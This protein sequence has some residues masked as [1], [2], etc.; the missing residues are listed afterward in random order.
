MPPASEKLSRSIDVVKGSEAAAAISLGFAVFFVPL[1]YST[2][3]PYA[4]DGKWPISGACALAAGVLLLLRWAAGGRIPAAGAGVVRVAGLFIAAAAVSVAFSRYTEA[5]LR[6]T[7]WLAAHVI[8]FVAAAVVFRRREWANWFVGVVLA[9]AT[10]V[11]VYGCCQRLRIGDAGQTW[12]KGARKIEFA[13]GARVLGTIGLETALG[14]YMATCAV[15]AIGALLHFRKWWLRVLLAAAALLMI[16]CMIF[17]GTRT[18]W[19]AFAIGLIVSVAAVV[20][21]REKGLFRGVDGVVTLGVIIAGIVAAVPAGFETALGGYVA[22]CAVL[23]IGALLHLRKWWLRVLLAAA[24]LLMIACMIFSGT[25]TAWFAFAIGLIVSV[26]AVVT[27]REKGAFCRLGRLAAI[28]VFI[29]GIAAVVG[30]SFPSVGRRL[31]AVRKHLPGRVVIWRSAVGMF[32]ASPVVGTGPG[33]FTVHFAEF[34]PLDYESHQVTSVVLHAHCEYLDV[35]AETG[36]LGMVSF[37]LLIGLI[38]VGSVRALRRPGGGGRP[39]LL[40]AFAASVTMLAHAVA[41]VD[42]RYPTCWLMLWVMMG[43][44]AAR[45]QDADEGDRA[46]PPRTWPW[47][48]FVVIA[49]VAVA[50]VIWDAQVWRPYQ[51]RKHLEKADGRQKKGQWAESIE[52]AQRALELDPISVPSHCVLANSLLYAGEYDA[53]LEAFRRLQVHSPNYADIHVRIGVLNALLGRMDEARR[54]LRL[55][56]RYGVAEGALADADALSDEQL[57]RRA[58][59]FEK[60]NRP[61]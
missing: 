39:L 60:K 40:A 24:A 52:S 28:G 14:G 18:A 25:R 54:A 45:W 10:L 47:R 1:C 34:R 15:L 3:T 20:V 31:R 13:L 23:A 59:A 44:A 51:A 48:A 12:F 7:W 57:R 4:L 58:I 55:A 30:F 41:S 5:G 2:S 33:T 9:A 27:G 32:Q 46:S 29:A 37:M 56:R 43:L 50:V 53:A 11:A 6:E 17:S 35:L 38:A 36:M 49:G 61:R 16:S 21:R 19:F 22:I 26:A 8:F 42:T